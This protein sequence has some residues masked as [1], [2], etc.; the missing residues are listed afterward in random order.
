MKRIYVPLPDEVARRSL[1]T[2][3][4]LKHL[5]SANKN[6]DNGTASD[7][8]SVGHARDDSSKSAT[9]SRSTLQISPESA[10]SNSSMFSSITSLVL[11]PDTKG[12]PQHQGQTPSG[13]SRS[14]VPGQSLGQSAAGFSEAD[15]ARIV[16]LTEG[17]SGSDLTAASTV[18]SR[19]MLN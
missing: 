16:A 18:F 13:Q 17:Y 3:L 12:S 9:G 19:S 4:I 6:T 1:I 2:H 7:T 5:R 11:G 14:L 8:A 10:K 15:M